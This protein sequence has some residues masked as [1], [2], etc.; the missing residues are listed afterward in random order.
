VEL[1]HEPGAFSSLIGSRVSDRSGRAIGRIFE[2]RAHW[3]GDGSI[4]VDELIVGRRGLWRRL[5]GPKTGQRGIPWEAVT[6]VEPGRIVVSA[7][8]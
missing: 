3:E 5:R 7:D 1:N 2:V 4:L 6:E 8:D